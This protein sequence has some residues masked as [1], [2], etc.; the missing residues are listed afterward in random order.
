[1]AGGAPQ[2]GAAGP[3]VGDDAPGPR[4][5]REAVEALN[6]TVEGPG[7]SYDVRCVTTTERRGP[8]DT[9]TVRP[10]QLMDVFHRLCLLQP[11]ES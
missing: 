8:F 11:G 9:V 7:G 1:M 2:A 4:R 3:S 5:S 6:I 10:D